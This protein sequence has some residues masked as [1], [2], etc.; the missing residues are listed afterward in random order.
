MTELQLGCMAE[1]VH[2]YKTVQIVHDAT[3]RLRQHH[4]LATHPSYNSGWF[5]HIRD[6]FAF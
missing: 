5:P 6:W 1:S 2:G 4:Q 3:Q